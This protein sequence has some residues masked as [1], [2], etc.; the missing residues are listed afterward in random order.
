[1]EGAVVDQLGIEASITGVRDVLFLPLILWPW[2]AAGHCQLLTS[3]MIP[4]INGEETFPPEALTTRLTALHE[5][6]KARAAVAA[7]VS[8]L[9]M[10]YDDI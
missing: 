4:Y 3:C 9:I 7:A 5:D 2:A 6:T 8:S 1:L 10:N